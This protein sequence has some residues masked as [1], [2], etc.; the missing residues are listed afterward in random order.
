VPCRNGR[1]IVRVAENARG[2]KR[3][4]VNRPLP[5]CPTR[6]VPFEETV[7]KKQDTLTIVQSDLS[8]RLPRRR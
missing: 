5:N 3:A 1:R 2:R 8:R 6:A 7:V 4:G